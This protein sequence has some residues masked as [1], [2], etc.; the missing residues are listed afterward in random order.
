MD[1]SYSHSAFWLKQ[2]YQCN[3]FFNATAE[4]I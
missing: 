1:T 4:L 2:Q 3:T